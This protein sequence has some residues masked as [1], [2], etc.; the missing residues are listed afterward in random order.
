MKVARWFGIEKTMV[1]TEQGMTKA[2][3][4][5]IFTTPGPVLA[6]AKIAISE[7]PWQLP[8]KDGAAIGRRFPSLISENLRRAVVFR[9]QQFS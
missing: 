2:L 9:R 1:V 6:V 3:A 4:D 5:F 8:E 7:D